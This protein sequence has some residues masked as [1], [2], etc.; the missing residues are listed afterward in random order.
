MRDLAKFVDP[1]VNPNDPFGVI[2]NRKHLI[3]AK[4]RWFITAI[5]TPKLGPHWGSPRT[6]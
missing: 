1:T 2:E 6:K 4:R 3:A 5:H